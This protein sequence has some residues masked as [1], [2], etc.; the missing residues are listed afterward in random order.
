[1]LNIADEGGEGIRKIKN[2]H[3]YDMWLMYLLPIWF[4]IV[5]QT[6]PLFSEAKVA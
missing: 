6:F 1:M 4:L 2:L 5:L 3:I